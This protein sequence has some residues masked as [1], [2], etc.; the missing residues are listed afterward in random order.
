IKKYYQHMNKF[1]KKKIEEKKIKKIDQ[2][3]DVVFMA[4]P[5][6][7]ARDMAESF[8]IK[9]VKVIDLSGDFRIKNSD[10]YTQWYGINHAE[11][12]LVNR[13]VYGLTEWV[14]EDLENV[15][16]IANPGCFPTSSY[17]A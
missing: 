4:T 3:V 15:N 14:K 1:I 11:K 6:G 8:L 5:S 9:G 17:L 12:K 2:E 7:V 16:F 10:V 13:A